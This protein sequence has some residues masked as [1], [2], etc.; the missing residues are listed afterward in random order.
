[1]SASPEDFPRRSPIYR[2]LMKL[3]ARF[4]EVAGCA[5]ALRFADDAEQEAAQ[6]RELGLSDLYA[7]PRG[8]YKGWDNAGYLAKCGVK[9]GEATNE[10]SNLAYPQA[11]GSLIA[12]LAASE[13]LILSALDGTSAVL[14][15]LEAGWS[16]AAGEGAYPVPRP[17][18]NCW[19]LVTG[20]HAGP[21]F[22]KICGVDLRPEKFANH[23][24]AQTS[25]AR[26]ASIVIR[27]DLGRVP[28]FHLL[29]DSAS[30]A[31]M[32]DCLLDA[33]EEF[34]GRPVGLDAIRA[35]ARG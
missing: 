9:A 8:G 35:L 32:W 11:D 4:G 22:A 27:A 30:A 29:T 21:M 26:L 14:D 18:T 28:A 12:R 23:R 10:A 20:R 3:G 34:A 25:V 13:V 5:A 19:F 17:D 2:E 31:Y 24:V 15:K 7:L 33:A 6:A 16:M 1:M